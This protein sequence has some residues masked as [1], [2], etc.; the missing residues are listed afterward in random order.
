[1]LADPPAG[2]CA[3]LSAAVCGSEVAGLRTG[4]VGGTEEPPALLLGGCG[5]GAFLGRGL[6]TGGWISPLQT[7]VLREYRRPP[8]PKATGC[9]ALARGRC[10]AP[11]PSRGGSSKGAN[12]FVCFLLAPV[13]QLAWFIWQLRWKIPSDLHALI[14]YILYEE[15]K[16]CT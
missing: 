14:L 7:S 9:P 1:M 8:C 13:S 3:E 15:L 12:G 5:R 2:L 11:S 10:E 4:P 6:I 16:S